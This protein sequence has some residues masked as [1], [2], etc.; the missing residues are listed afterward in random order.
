[1]KWTISWFDVVGHHGEIYSLHLFRFYEFNQ[2]HQKPTLGLKKV[3]LR[4]IDR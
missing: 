3:S 2:R 1:M 4:N